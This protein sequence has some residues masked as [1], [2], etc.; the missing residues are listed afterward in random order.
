MA[1]EVYRAIVN[2]I[3]TGALRE[4]F[5]KENFRAACSGFRNGTYNAFVD[6]HRHGNPGGNSELFERVSPA[7]FKCLRPFR[8]GI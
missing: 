7:Q 3:R 8:Y 4:P 2:A 5:S 6:K 1:H